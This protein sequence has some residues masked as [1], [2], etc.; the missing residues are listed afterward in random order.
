MMHIPNDNGAESGLDSRIV[1]QDIA[2]LV[3]DDNAHRHHVEERAQQI[4]G[5]PDFHL[6]FIPPVQRLAG[7]PQPLQD[8]RELIPQP[9]RVLALLIGQGLQPFLRSLDP[10]VE[11][12]LLHISPPSL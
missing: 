3:A 4:I 6:T 5:H 2:I 12:V 1:H 9:R 8:G 11:N 10:S 7:R